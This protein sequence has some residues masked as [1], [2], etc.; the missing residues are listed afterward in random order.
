MT[1]EEQQEIL[2]HIGNLIHESDKLQDK[3]FDV[4]KAVGDIK[5]D[6]ESEA[7]NEK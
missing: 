3:I 1:R 2:K 4:F 5:I 6:K 7:V